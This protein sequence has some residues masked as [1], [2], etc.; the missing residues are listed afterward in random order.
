[1]HGGLSENGGSGSR[2]AATALQLHKVIDLHN[3]CPLP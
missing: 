1:M 3:R 2:P